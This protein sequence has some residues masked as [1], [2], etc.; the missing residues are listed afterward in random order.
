MKSSTGIF[1]ANELAEALL[2]RAKMIEAAAEGNEELVTKYLET[3]SLSDDEIRLG[4][5]ARAI[6]NESCSPCAARPSR[7]RACRRSWMPSSN[8]CPR[9]GDA[10]GQGTD[11]RDQPATRSASDDA[12]FAGLAFKILNDPY[13]GNLTF[14]RVYSGTLNSGRY[15]LRDRPRAGRSASDG[16]CR[17][18]RATAPRSKK[19]A[20]ATLPPPWV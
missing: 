14:F 9:R 12:P 10:A 1:P 7:T 6:K 16:S 4:L 13:V 18:M 17:C 15:R 2:W 19:C 5:R 3:S 11:D 20:R 8:S